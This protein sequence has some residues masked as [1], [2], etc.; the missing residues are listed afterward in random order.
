M[1]EINM[2][3][4]ATGAEA[5][6]AAYGGE[7]EAKIATAKADYTTANQH[8][9]ILHHSMHYGCPRYGT[10]LLLKQSPPSL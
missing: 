9:G 6:G 5:L 3:A 4:E 10:A 7:Q 8:S 1:A 2:S